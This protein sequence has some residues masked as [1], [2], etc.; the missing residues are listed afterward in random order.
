[1]QA[2]VKLTCLMRDRRTVPIKYPMTEVIVNKEF[3]DDIKSLVNFILDEL[4]VRDIILSS[5]KQ[6]YKQKTG[7]KSGNN[8]HCVIPSVA[9]SAKKMERFS[10]I[11]HQRE[12]AQGKLTTIL[13]SV[14]SATTLTWATL[15]TCQK[16][17]EAAYDAY[18]PSRE[19][20]IITH[21]PCYLPMLGHTAYGQILG[22]VSANLRDEQDALHDAFDDLHTEV[23]T[24]IEEKLLKVSQPT[25]R[26]N[27]YT[28]GVPQWVD[29]T[30]NPRTTKVIGGAN[31]AQK[32]S[33]KLLTEQ[34]DTEDRVRPE[35]TIPHGERSENNHKI[36][37]PKT[38]IDTCKIADEKDSSHPTK[39]PPGQNAKDNP[40]QQQMAMTAGREPAQTCDVCGLGQHKSWK[41]PQF[42]PEHGVNL[43]ALRETSFSQVLD[44]T[45]G[46]GAAHEEAVLIQGTEFEDRP[47]LEQHTEASAREDRAYKDSSEDTLDGH[48]ANE[49]AGVEQMQPRSDT[50]MIPAG[51]QLTVRVNLVALRETSFSQVLDGT[52][53]SGAAHEEAVLIQGT[54]FE[55]RP[56]LEQHTEASAREDRAYKDSSEVS[57][58]MDFKKTYLPFHTMV[59]YSKTTLAFQ[60]ERFLSNDTRFKVPRR[61]AL[62]QSVYMRRPKNASWL[63]EQ[64]TRTRAASAPHK[65][66][67]VDTHLSDERSKYPAT[68]APT[69][70]KKSGTGRSHSHERS[71]YA[72]PLKRVTPDGIGESPWRS[73]TRC[74]FPTIGKHQQSLEYIPRVG[75]AFWQP[76][77]L[78]TALTGA[79]CKNVT[80]ISPVLDNRAKGDRI[81]LRIPRALGE[82]LREHIPGQSTATQR[83]VNLVAL[84]ETSFSQVLDGTIGSGAAHEEAVLIQGTEFE[85]RP[86]L[87]QH[88]EASAEKIEPTRIQ[89]SALMQSVYMRRPKNASWL[90]EQ[91][92]RTRAASAPHKAAAVDTHLSDERS[93]YPA[94]AAPAWKKKSGTGRSHSHE[95]SVYANPLKRVTPDGIGESPWRGTTR[96]RFPTIGKH[97][98]SLEYIPRVGQA[99]WQPLRLSTALT[100]ASCKNVTKISPGLDNRAKGDRIDLRIPRAPG[101]ELRE[102]IPGQTSIH[103][104]IR[105][106]D[107]WIV[108][109]T[110][111]Q[112]LH[113]GRTQGDDSCTW[114]ELT[115]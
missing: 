18:R 62:M 97:Q 20:G 56:K 51:A 69:W 88:T 25:R 113:R 4:N 85:D 41:C 93:K 55:D 78:S 50:S 38:I 102:H 37:K 109:P 96:C 10:E 44:G 13:E 60:A 74:R 111:Y 23:L 73:T 22:M 35:F 115:T 12:L 75:Q 19:K 108:S 68:A 3:L 84:R 72:N 39:K 103:P 80:K 81:D 27:A 47:K 57:D 100:G 7:G 11:V 76:L 79:S 52:I 106:D 82:E 87:E 77:R 59:Q 64:M 114:T 98:Q 89:V 86:K 29:E 112:R 58:P 16:D 92:T 24:V 8:E 17:V 48:N 91:M 33:G 15:K 31:E 63:V 104:G 99:F 46:S 110:A 71:V 70:K 40:G 65:A 36:E 2:V 101:E 67:A 105:T 34:L 32:R 83:R 49:M 107:L 94:T 42:L 28:P 95:R 1:M 66:A 53:G 14:A 90:V 26:R 61:S 45:I 54:E 9:A 30:T 21:F 5:G 43:V 6:K